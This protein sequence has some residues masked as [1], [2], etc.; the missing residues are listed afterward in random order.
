MAIPK[1]DEDHIGDATFTN[2]NRS[3]GFINSRTKNLKQAK[4]F[5]KFL[6]TDEQDLD[7]KVLLTSGTFCICAIK[8]KLNTKAIT[9]NLQLVMQGLNGRVTTREVY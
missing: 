3:Y 8:I 4:E 2:L 5:F 7:N 1:V 6:H 9:C